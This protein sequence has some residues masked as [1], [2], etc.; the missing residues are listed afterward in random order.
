MSRDFRQLLDSQWEQG[1]FLCVGLDSEL[2]KIPEIAQKGSTEET[3][4]GFNRAIVDATR[5]IVGA[6]KPNIAFYEAHG[7]EGW[8]ALRSTIAYIQ[9]VAPDVPVILDAKRGDVGNSSAAYADAVFDHLHADAITIN[10]YL[11]AEALQPFL[12]RADKGVF[13]L[14]RTSNGGSGEFQDLKI[15]DEEL[16]KVVARHVA[17]TWNEK[18][19]CGLVAGA[20]YP[21]ELKL[22]REIIGDMPLL[23]PGIG[24]QNGD[25]GVSVQAA[26]NGSGAGMIINASRSILFAS[27]NADFA[28]AA[29]KEAVRIDGAIRAA[30]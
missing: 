24:A 18:Q 12:D 8:S 11:G 21:E 9:A 29:R 17:S 23:I 14:C 1:K 4:L 19:N 27:Q 28:E 7:D 3:L 26:K 15:Q 10:P 16:Y 22:V 13:V 25:I 20:T 30:L 6:F 2:E 5:D